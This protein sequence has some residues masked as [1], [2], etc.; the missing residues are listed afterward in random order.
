MRAN[1][2]CAPATCSEWRFAEL[3][4]YVF[5]VIFHVLTAARRRERVELGDFRYMNPLGN[6]PLLRLGTVDLAVFQTYQNR[7][8][9]PARI[10]PD[11]IVSKRILQANNSLSIFLA[12]LQFLD[13]IGAP[14]YQ[15][16]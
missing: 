11:E 8:A 3:Y 10:E 13:V 1:S 2:T 4:F 14:G 16:K 15:E 12:Q 6:Y 5:A 9:F 7:L